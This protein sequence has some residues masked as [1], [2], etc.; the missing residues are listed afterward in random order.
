M[1]LHSIL[2]C[3]LGIVAIMPTLVWA[4]AGITCKS[5][6]LYY[7]ASDCSQCSPLGGFSCTAEKCDLPKGI[8]SGELHWPASKALSVPAK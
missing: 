3:S 5:G 6:S 7:C 2:V 1:R 4:E 8:K